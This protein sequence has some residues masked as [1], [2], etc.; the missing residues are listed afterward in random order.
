MITFNTNGN[1]VLPTNYK[2]L[3][4]PQRKLVREEYIHIQEGESLN[5]G[6]YL[7]RKVYILIWQKIPN[8]SYYSFNEL[9]ENRQISSICY[10]R[11]LVV[12]GMGRT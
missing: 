1:I 7:K 4:I 9:R 10:V 5:L 3:T 11:N 2:Q 6:K 12:K 8:T